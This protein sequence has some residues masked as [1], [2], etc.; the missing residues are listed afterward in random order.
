M[1][2][3]GRSW[4]TRYRPDARHY[5]GAELVDWVALAS[6]AVVSAGELVA[7]VE[8]VSG[9]GALLSEVLGVLV[10]VDVV[11]W[12]AGYGARVGVWFWGWVGRGMGLTVRDGCG[13]GLLG[14]LDELP[15]LPLLLPLP[16]PLPGWVGAFCALTTRVAA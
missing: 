10:G 1:H 6:G 8:L 15:P 9:A 4:I 11:G 13:V 14:G 12:G 2:G 3:S 7:D 5:A 16:L